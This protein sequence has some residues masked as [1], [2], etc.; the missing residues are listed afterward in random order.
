ML[1]DIKPARKIVLHH[2]GKGDK[3]MSVVLPTHTNDTYVHYY[4]GLHDG[5]VAAAHDYANGGVGYHGCPPGHTKEY[6]V[7]YKQGYNYDAWALVGGPAF[8][9]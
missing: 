4:G 3:E 5:G 9:I 7:G 1:L 2:L 6:R 8:S